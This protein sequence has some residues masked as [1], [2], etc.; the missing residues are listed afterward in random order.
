VPL[1]VIRARSQPSGGW[2][3][4]LRVIWF[5][6]TAGRRLISEYPDG[7][8]GLVLKSYRVKGHRVKMTRLT[9]RPIVGTSR[10]PRWQLTYES[11]A[12]Q[13]SSLG[14]SG[15][16]LADVGNSGALDGADGSR[17]LVLRSPTLPNG[18]TLM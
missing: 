7:G 11:E 14:N 18:I 3:L 12:S 16:S 15:P 9:V 2:T 10:A 8:S 1:A 5:A 6:W 13:G 4:L 17:G